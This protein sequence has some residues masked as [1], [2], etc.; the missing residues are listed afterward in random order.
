[1]YILIM[2]NCVL[3]GNSRG[4]LAFFVLYSMASIILVLIWEFNIYMSVFLRV[5]LDF[6]LPGK[7]LMYYIK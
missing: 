4:C 6:S 1:M 5:F 3:G 2:I 7:F